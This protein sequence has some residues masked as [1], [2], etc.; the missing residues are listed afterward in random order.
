MSPG[1]TIPS[2]PARGPNLTPGHDGVRTPDIKSHI[3]SG[4]P[5]ISSTPWTARVGWPG[6]AGDL[7]GRESFKLRENAGVFIFRLSILRGVC[8]MLREGI[9][10]RCPASVSASYCD[11]R[12]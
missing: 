7:S 12:Y 4:D 10:A 2:L 1:G 3:T 11:N 9:H 5:W 8:M 6:R